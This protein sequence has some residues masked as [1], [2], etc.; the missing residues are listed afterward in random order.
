[1]TPCTK[2]GQSRC[3]RIVTP[4]ITKLLESGRCTDL[5]RDDPE[6]DREPG[7]VTR[8]EDQRQARVHHHLSQVV[9]TGDVLEPV[10]PGHRVL[11]TDH[12]TW[13]TGQRPAPV[14]VTAV[15]PNRWREPRT[16]TGAEAAPEVKQS[17]S[18]A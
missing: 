6:P 1:M 10:A 2:F 18:N 7:D 14:K 11:P 17:E 16:T 5:V 15:A 12:R 8:A 13:R 4:T 9:R 3:L